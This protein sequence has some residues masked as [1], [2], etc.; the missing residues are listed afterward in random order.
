MGDVG[1]R[2]G[3]FALVLGGTFGTSYALGEKL[4]GHSHD[5]SSSHSHWGEM[6]TPVL[7]A[8]ESSGYSLVNDSFSDES[9]TFRLVD[10]DGSLVT[11]FAV[12]HGSGI[13]AFV[14]PP[15]LSTLE[16]T[17]PSLSADG[18]WQVPL[19]GPGRWH[20]V[21]EATP[22]NASRSVLMATDVVNGSTAPSTGPTTTP[23]TGPQQDTTSTV[24]VGDLTVTREGLMFVVTKPDGTIVVDFEPYLGAGAHLVV[25]RV[26]DLAYIHLHDT[27]EMEGMV[28]FEGDIPTGSV[29][30]LFL[31]FATEGQ[32]YKVA[33]TLPASEVLE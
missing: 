15:D 23:A 17:H 31:Q 11:S 5:G 2:L 21:I 10:P 25:L 12:V 22:T 27:G 13:H 18:T 32:P 6:T 26:D 20:I 16:H 3:A 33:F 7:P 14:T 29:Y 9:A 19:P 1:R 4:P 30:R 24:Q 8:T 28:M